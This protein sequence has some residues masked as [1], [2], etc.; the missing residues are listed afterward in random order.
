MRSNEAADP[1]TPD[2]REKDE[3]RAGDDEGRAGDDTAMAG[4]GE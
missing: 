2:D 4:T 3:S 1:S